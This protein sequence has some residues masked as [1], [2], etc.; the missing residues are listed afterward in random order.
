MTTVKKILVTGADG[1]IGSHLSEALV[2]AGHEVRAMVMYN[3]FGH[4]GRLD[5]VDKQTLG[6]MEIFPA[7]IRDQG[8][9]KEAINDV[10]HVFHLASLIGIPYSYHAPESYV[11]TNVQGTLNLLMASVEQQVKRFVHTSTSEVYGSAQV[12]PMN[13]SHPLVG[14]SPYSASKIAADQMVTAF[15][16]SYDLD[17]VTVR[18]FNTYGPRQSARAIIPTIITQLASGES[19]LRLGST[20][21]RRDLTF[22]TDIVD[23]FVASLDNKNCSG[24]T[25]N[26]GSGGEISIGEL[27]HKISKLMKVSIK[28]KTDPA[29]VRPD[30]SEVTRLLADNSKAEKLL[31]WKPSV[32]LTEGLSR[33]IEYFS[34]PEILK[35]YH[36]ETYDI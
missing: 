22:V 34:D 32:D 1:F 31:G 35:N 33:T 29:R 36:P 8:R 10:S 3:A 6:K 30:K 18:P 4:R 5:F 27:A 26:L 17:A 7:D 14:Q 28:I 9:V 12:L 19:T 11:A 15:S 2:Q 16:R 20:E 21:P 24:E 13:E 25:I 23:G